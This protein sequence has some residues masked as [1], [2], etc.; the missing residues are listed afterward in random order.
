M[1]DNPLK[2]SKLAIFGEVWY[3]MKQNKKWFIGPILVSLILL[4]I[5][6]VFAEGSALAPFIYTLF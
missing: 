1:K 4:G 2:S 5:V 3:L 6:I